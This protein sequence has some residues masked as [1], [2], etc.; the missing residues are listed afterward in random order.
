MGSNTPA[1]VWLASSSTP[2]AHSSSTLSLASGRRTSTIKTRVRSFRRYFRWLRAARLKDYPSEVRD[3]I[4]FLQVLSDNGSSRGVLWS[5][6]S[7]FAFMEQVSGVSDEMIMSKNKIYLNVHAELLVQSLQGLPPR[8]APRPDLVLLAALEDY[9]HDTTGVT[10]LRLQAWWRLVKAWAV[11]RHNDLGGLRPTDVWFDD[12]G[13]YSHLHQSQRTG[14]DKAVRTRPINVSTAAYIVYPGWLATGLHLLM[15]C[16]RGERDFLLPSPS[17]KGNRANIFPIS[18]IDSTILFHQLFRVLTV[19]TMVGGW[20]RLF[21]PSVP[22]GHWREHSY[23]SFLPSAAA[24]LNWVR[25]DTDFLGCWR[26][27]GGAAYSRTVRTKIFEMQRVGRRG[28]HARPV[29]RQ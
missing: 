13:M 16:P 20:T 8:P 18:H 4:E 9:L 5:A 17:E 2:S 28:A 21:D 7:S 14:G 3:F 1:G 24:A 19:P 29:R 27:Q 6:K 22:L 15:D 26:A 10:A 23:R 12:E 25:A 11:L